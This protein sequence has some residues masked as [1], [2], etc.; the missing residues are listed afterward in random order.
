M[1]KIRFVIILIHFTFCA[2]GQKKISGVLTYSQITA[3]EDTTKK[4]LIPVELFF[5]QEE[6]VTLSGILQKM[7]KD[8][9]SRVAPPQPENKRSA[10]YIN[11]GTNRMMSRQKADTELVI[12]DDF[13]EKIDW[14]I[15]PE[16]KKIGTIKCQKAEAKVR[17]RVYI[18]WFAPEI[19]VRCGP[20]KLYGLPGLILHAKSSDNA[21]E[22]KFESLKMPAPGNFTIEPLVPL[23]RM[24]VVSE[25][26][27]L[28]KK[29]INEDNFMKMIKSDP[30]LKDGNVTFSMKS[31]EIYPK[32]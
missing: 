24:K 25:K 26:E 6:S 15:I 3:F 31:I 5:S 27:F 22:F 29:R 14:K 18:A 4:N 2:L 11:F 1:R 19:P 30:Q 32:K 9:Q 17:G 23:P 10:V 28:K 20:W 8:G 12:V 13:L 7:D 21:V 16:T